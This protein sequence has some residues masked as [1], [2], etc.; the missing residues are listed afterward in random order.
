[1]TYFNLHN[2][3]FLHDLPLFVPD[4]IFHALLIMLLYER[5]LSQVMLT[6]NN[7]N[8]KTPHFFKGIFKNEVR[9]SG[10][11]LEVVHEY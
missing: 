11:R 8:I 1:M 7:N 3:V 2:V 10:L 5:L 6:K 4:V 9:S